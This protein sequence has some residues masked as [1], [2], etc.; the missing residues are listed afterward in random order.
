MQSC[1]KKPKH[2]QLSPISLLILFR[3][4]SIISLKINCVKNIFSW[5]HCIILLVFFKISSIIKTIPNALYLCTIVHQNLQSKSTVTTF[6]TIADWNNVDCIKC[7]SCSLWLFTL[8]IFGLLGFSV[9]V[10][11]LALM[12]YIY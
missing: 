9:I 4:P 5:K 1:V 8:P 10:S 12:S 2:R 6:E 7:F 11:S 3:L